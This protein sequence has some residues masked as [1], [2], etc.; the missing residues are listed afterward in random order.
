MFAAT[1]AIRVKD[2]CVELGSLGAGESETARF[3]AR[4]VAE[5][6]PRAYP[7]SFHAD[8]NGGWYADAEATV[9]VKK[10]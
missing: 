8:A 5:A 10:R 6:K 7:L 2:Q 1:R 4:A 3:R 9:K